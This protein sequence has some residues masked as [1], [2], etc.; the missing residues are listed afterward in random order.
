MDKTKPTAPPKPRT[1]KRPKHY[2]IAFREREYFSENL[3]LLLETAVPIGQAIDSLGATAGSKAMKRAL[4]AMQVDI[5]AGYSLSDALGRSGIVSTQTL[6]LIRLG[7]QSGNLIENLQLAAQQE[8]KRHTFQAKVRSALLYPT[9]VLTLTLVIGIA[10]AWFLLPQLSAT[11]SQLNVKLPLIS[12]IMINF[13]LFLKEHGIVVVPLFLSV[14]AIIGYI[15]FGAPKT[16][17]IGRR[18]LF[19]LPGIGRLM[20]EVEIA[21]FGYLLGTL[22]EAGLPITQAVTL[23]VGA[24]IAPQYQK[25]YRYLAASLDDGYSFKDSMARYKHSEKLLPPAVQQMVISGER[26]GSLS[27]VLL[28]IG[29]TYEQKSDITTSNLE[30]ITEPILLL[31][32]AGGVMLVAVAVILPIYSL[33]GGLNQ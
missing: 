13:G 20:R 23:L 31:F 5:G 15:L 30:T 33:V 6:A 22:L 24:S 17:N 19:K 2:H 12:Q 14:L 3:A 26:S 7:E 21:Q 32:V 1:A 4:A 9:F 25:F 18:F 29:R 28:K 8:D 10:V 27:K 16:K 11:F